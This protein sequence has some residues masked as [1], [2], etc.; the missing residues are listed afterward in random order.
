M[1]YI[2]MGTFTAVWRIILA[3]DRQATCV[4]DKTRKGR[5]GFVAAQRLDYSRNL[6]DSQHTKS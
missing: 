2:V 6:R 5:K 4:N 1:F 3:C